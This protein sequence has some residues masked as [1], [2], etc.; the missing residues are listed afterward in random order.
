MTILARNALLAS[1][2]TTITVLII[3]ADADNTELASEKIKVSKHTLT[4]SS[5]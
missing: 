4:Q 1:S 2:K 3:K 5:K